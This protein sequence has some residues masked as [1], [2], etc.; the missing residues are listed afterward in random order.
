MTKYAYFCPNG[1]MVDLTEIDPATI[2]SAE[3]AAQFEVVPDDIEANAKKSVD[4]AGKA[5][6]AVEKFEPVAA[7]EGNKR[8]SQA[9][10][11]ATLTRAERTALRSARASNEVAD[12]FMLM[13]E[14]RKVLI[15]NDESKADL[16]QFVTDKILSQASVDAVLASA[17]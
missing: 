1:S 15:I 10:F 2:F 4:S 17:G 11:L 7:P 14:T 3:Y 5:S 9:D 12:D 8:L 6:Y 13:L 16:A